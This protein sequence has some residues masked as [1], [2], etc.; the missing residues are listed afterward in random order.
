MHNQFFLSVVLVLN[1]SVVSNLSK[2]TVLCINTE[3]E[4]SLK[5]KFRLKAPTVNGWANRLCTQWDLW[6]S[7]EGGGLP[8][9][10]KGADND[11]NYANLELPQLAMD[12]PIHRFC[13]A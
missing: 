1:H 12:N 7:R 8:A 9:R 2:N 11:V 6:I 4:I 5:L 13:S 10:F 3:I